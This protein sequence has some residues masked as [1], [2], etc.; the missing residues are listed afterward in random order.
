[1]SAHACAVVGVP[2]SSSVH[3]EAEGTSTPKAVKIATPDQSPFFVVGA[4]R[5]G[6]TLLRL[7]LTSHPEVHVPRETWFLIDLMDRLPF[8]RP[9]R[10]RDVQLAES[11]ICNHPRWGD[12]E[13]SDSA[14]HD[15]FAAHAEPRLRDLVGSLYKLERQRVG[16]P[17][18]G[19]KTPGYVTHIERLSR[20]L[21]ESRFIHIIRDA[22]DTSRSLLNLVWCGRQTFRAAHYWARSVGA[23]IE[24]GRKLPP[25]RYLEVSYEE[26][27]L[28]P[29]DTT[30]SICAFLDVSF[31]PQMLAFHRDSLR[32]VPA[33]ARRHHHKLARPPRPE[34]IG[35]WSR[36]LSR[37]DIFFVEAMAGHVMGRVGQ[38]RVFPTPVS[39][40]RFGLGFLALLLETTH[41]LR[42][43]LGLDGKRLFASRRVGAGVRPG[44][45]AAG[46]PDCRRP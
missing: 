24:Q 37:R 35:I 28:R 32:H 23:G 30:R 34:D 21:P 31:D 11:I 44:G 9:L 13:I 46:P 5:S 6:T 25:E 33:W 12:W 1:M 41:P 17:I 20:L 8:D 40:L 2:S 39:L 38:E 36:E 29:A 18:W 7:I 10:T 19:D 27:V 4:S 43:R 45:L 3:A 26:L 15:A 16:K 42:E 22:R 14:L